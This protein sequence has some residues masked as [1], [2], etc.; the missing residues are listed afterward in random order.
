MKKLLS[1]YDKISLE[2]VKPDFKERLLA[3][4]D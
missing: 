3:N 1:E 4:E 2:D